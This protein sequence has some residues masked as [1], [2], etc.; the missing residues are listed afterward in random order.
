[1]KFAVFESGGFTTM[2]SGLEELVVKPLKAQDG[3]AFPAGARNRR[4]AALPVLFTQRH[5]SVLEWRPLP[6]GD[7]LFGII[8]AGFRETMTR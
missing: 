8:H 6:V 4:R 5:R 2:F 1:V 3:I 7:L